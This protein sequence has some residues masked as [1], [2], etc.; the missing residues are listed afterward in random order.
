MFGHNVATVLSISHATYFKNQL[1]FRNVR[2]RIQ[3][4]NKNGVQ[5]TDLYSLSDNEIQ[6]CL[7]N[8]N[9]LV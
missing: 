2:S 8:T 4:Q 3:S 6:F 5:K 1:K 9:M 7:F